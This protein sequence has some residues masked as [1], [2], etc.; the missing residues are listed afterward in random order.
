[1]LLWAVAA[2]AFGVGLKTAASICGTH[3]CAADQW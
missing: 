3:Q 2:E 1:M